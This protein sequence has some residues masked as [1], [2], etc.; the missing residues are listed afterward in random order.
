MVLKSL[1][2]ASNVFTLT[3][4]VV[5]FA[6]QYSVAPGKTLM[7]KKFGLG[8]YNKILNCCVALCR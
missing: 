2:A 8:N 6:Y 7:K 1:M 3:L 5:F 4:K